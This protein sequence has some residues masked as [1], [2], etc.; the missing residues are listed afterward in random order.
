MKISARMP[1]LVCVDKY[2]GCAKIIVLWRGMSLTNTCKEKAKKYLNLATELQILLNT[3]F[4][5]IWSIGHSSIQSF[6]FLHLN[7]INIR[8]MMKT[9]LLR[10]QSLE[11]TLNSTDPVKLKSCIY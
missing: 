2:S 5:S 6:K 3:R 10:A 8:Q 4:E 7:E 11:G 9:V 1:D